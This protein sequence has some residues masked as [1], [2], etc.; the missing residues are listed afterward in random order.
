MHRYT[1]RNDNI[2]SCRPTSSLLHVTLL[3]LP[4]PSIP[5]IGCQ[6][7]ACELTQS[8]SLVSA[9]SSRIFGDILLI[10]ATDKA[11]VWYKNL[12]VYCGKKLRSCQHLSF[13]ASDLFTM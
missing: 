5:G 3:P 1:A 9:T 11:S 2:R 12:S 4:Q 13:S 6:P 8:K 7:Y 10:F